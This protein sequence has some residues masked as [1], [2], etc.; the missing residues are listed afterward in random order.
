MQIIRRN[1]LGN[2]TED[3]STVSSLLTRS[4]SVVAI[5]GYDVI[6]IQTAA[7]LESPIKTPLGSPIQSTPLS[8]SIISGAQSTGAQPA[9]GPIGRPAPKLFDVLGLAIK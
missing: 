8:G 9:L 5:D 7:P 4:S 2:D 1:R 3:I 6:N